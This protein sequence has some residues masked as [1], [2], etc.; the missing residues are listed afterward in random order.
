MGDQFRYYWNWIQIAWYLGSCYKYN[1]FYI[2][3][4]N[5][6]TRNVLEF[7]YVKI[8]ADDDDDDLRNIIYSYK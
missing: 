3:L 4:T 8:G 1:V 7:V 5:Y 2:L 6:Y